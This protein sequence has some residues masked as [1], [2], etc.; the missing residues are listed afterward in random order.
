MAKKP[1]VPPE[2]SFGGQIFDALVILVLVAASLFAPIALRLAG[3][4]KADL[5]FADKSFAGMGQTPLMQQRWEQLGYN[6]D[7]A[8]PLIASRFDYSFSWVALIITALVI[9]GYFVFLVRYSD[10]E[11]REIIAERFDDR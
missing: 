2:Q 11:Y 1:Y 5:T 6:A 8:A 7:T 3:G 10:K 9:I 4:G